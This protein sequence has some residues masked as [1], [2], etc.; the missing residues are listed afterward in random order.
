MDLLVK[1]IHYARLNVRNNPE[2]I[3][4]NH[5]ICMVYNISRTFIKLYPQI[6]MHFILFGFYFE[7][8]VSRFVGKR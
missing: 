2:I 8:H 5:L 7:Q 6:F 4:R 1:R 3:L